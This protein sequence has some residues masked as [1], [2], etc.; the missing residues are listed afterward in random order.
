MKMLAVL[1]LALLPL[2]LLALLSS[3]D[4]AASAR[5]SRES[6][7]RLLAE[8]S[9][10]RLSSTIARTAISLRAATTAVSIARPDVAGCQMTLNALAA[11]EQHAVRFAVFDSQRTVICA[12]EGFAPPFMAPPNQGG[13]VTTRL[14]GEDGT[15]RFVV[16]GANGQAVGVAEL[17][18]ETIATRAYPIESVDNF[19]IELSQDGETYVVRH[20]NGGNVPSDASWVRQPVANGQIV[21]SATFAATPLRV[22]EALSIALPILMWLAAA[23][24]GW[25]AVS[26]LLLTPLARLRRAVV[27]YGTH[28]DTFQLPRIRTPA[29]EIRDLGEAFR[30]AIETLR[31][32]EQ[33]LAAGLVEQRRLTREVHHRVKNNLQVVASLLSLHARAAKN[34]EAAEAYA[35]IQR[36]VDALAIVQRNLFAELEHHNG[37]PVRQILAELAS[38]LHQSAPSDID[39]AISLDVANVRVSQ[40]VAVPVAFLVTEL[41]ELAMHCGRRFEIDISV[42]T[43]EED[44]TAALEVASEVF[45]TAE[46]PEAFARYERVLTGLARQLRSGLAKGDDGRCYQIVIPTL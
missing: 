36:R 2:G 23:L 25:L 21:F 11:L 29:V 16:A 22:S 5:E 7:A 43:N 42:T 37:L 8:V 41:V 39:I 27:H 10:R 40:D 45:V 38:G 14:D 30:Q 28:E 33:D 44:S 6:S 35:S 12:T 4:T 9:A 26:R 24:L 15:I 46:A 32:N 31:R 20:W 1:S 19:Q 17:P 18:A 3:L 34:P 13:G